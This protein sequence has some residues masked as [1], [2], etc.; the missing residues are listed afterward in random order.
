MAL[1]VEAKGDLQKARNRFQAVFGHYPTQDEVARFRTVA[2]PDALIP[3]N[4]DIA[5][6]TALSNNPEMKVNAFDVSAARKEI[7]ISKSAYYPA[8]NLFAKAIN[9]YD[10]DGQQGYRRDYAA[11]VEFNYNLF[12]GGRDKAGI[13]AALEKAGAA[14]AHL[15]YTKKLVIEQVQNSWELLM[16]LTQRN[17]LLDQQ[18]D[19]LKNFLDLAKKERKMG[20]RSLLD[21]LNGE[22][23]YINAQANAVAAKEDIK[24]AA[25]NLLF[26]MGKMD[27]SLF[28]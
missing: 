17:E 2:F 21:V 11:G 19:I 6:E 28:E 15:A 20:T 22:V 1:R 7:K 4:L 23:N 10:N 9:A 27:I 8:I 14:S 16:T 18:A 5:I 12:S 3:D 25:F 13:R 26:D 24:I